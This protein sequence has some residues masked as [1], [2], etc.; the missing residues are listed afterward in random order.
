MKTIGANI[1]KSDEP[2][3]NSVSVDSATA[4]TLVPAKANRIYLSVSNSNNQS[5]WVK[6]QASSIDN[7]KTGIYIL[8]GGH[9]EM[10]EQDKYTGEVSVIMANG[11]TKLIDFIEM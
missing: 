1:N 7:V 6:Y 2:E 9:W 5:V 3:N 10:P 4:V 8:P 11:G